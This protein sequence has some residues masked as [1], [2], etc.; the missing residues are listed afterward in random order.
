[1]PISELEIA[2]FR[3]SRAGLLE[4]KEGSFRQAFVLRPLMLF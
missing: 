1:M 2:I 3:I 4:R